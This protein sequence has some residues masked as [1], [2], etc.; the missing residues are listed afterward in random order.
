MGSVRDTLWLDHTSR[1]P[2]MS[3][4]SHCDEILVYEIPHKSE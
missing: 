3:L 4:A 2:A 1:T